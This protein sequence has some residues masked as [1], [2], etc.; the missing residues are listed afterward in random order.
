MHIIKWRYFQWPSAT[1]NCPKPHHF[2]H[3]V[4]SFISSYWMEIH[5]SN[6]VG[7]LIVASASP[8]MTNCSWRGVVTGQRSCKPFKFWWPPTISLER[9]KPRV[10]KFCTQVDYIKSRLTEYEWQTTR[11]NGAWSESHDPF[12]VSMPTIISPEWLKQDSPNFVHR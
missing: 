11:Q 12:S 6:M 1:P 10:V 4:S 8:W 3:F 5:T 9:L 7:T 2:P